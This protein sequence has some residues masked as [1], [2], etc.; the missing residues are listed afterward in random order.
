MVEGIDSVL[1]YVGGVCSE[2]LI[3]NYICQIQQK[4]EA[5]KATSNPNEVVYITDLGDKVTVGLVKGE[6]CRTYTIIVQK[7]PYEFW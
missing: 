6:K 5:F 1:Y 2:G 7:T 4:V 3:D